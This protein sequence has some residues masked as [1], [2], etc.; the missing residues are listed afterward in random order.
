MKNL[1]T[2]LSFALISCIS[3]SQSSSSLPHNLTIHEKLSAL[4]SGY[5][6]PE[7]SE[8][9][10]TTPPPY[11]NLRAMAEWEEIQALVVSWTSYTGI[12]KQIVAASVGECHVIILSENP[13]ST[14]SYLQNS[15]YGGAVSMNNITIIDTN[16]NSI[17]VRDYGGTTVYGNEVDNGLLVDWIYNR[18]R[19]ADDITPAV[20]ASALGLDIYTTTSAPYDFM[21]TGGN[22][23]SDGFGTAFS[24]NLIL[25]ENSGGSTGWGGSFPNHTESEID[26]IMN[27][28]MGIDT[29]IKMPNLP[30]DGIH[31]ID[32]HMKLLDEETLLVSQYP[33]GTADGP[34]I[35]ANIQYVLQNYTTKW[36]TPFDVHWITA[37]PQQ[38]GGYPNSGGYY[39]TY[40]NSMFVNKTLLVP[41][42]YE[43]YDTTALRIYEE[44]LPGYTIVPIDCDNSPEAIISASGA[45]HCITHEIGVEDPLLISFQ[46]LENEV[47][48]PN[49]HTVSAYI[50]HRDGISLASI[51]WRVQGSFSFIPATMTS[52][53]GGYFE[54]AI[55]TLSGDGGVIEY[56][57]QA[58]SYSGKVQRRPMTAPSGFKSFTILPGSGIYGCTDVNACNYDSTA[59][60]DDGTCEP[61]CCP[62]DINGDGGMNVSDLLVI[63]SEF[64]CS[65]DCTADIDSDGSVT[66]G[67]ILYFLSIFSDGCP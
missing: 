34:Q 65:S 64:G 22:Y 1:L 60:I 35:E 48:N 44:L 66:V 55:P 6:R 32:M 43:Q 51:Y 52:I 41:T 59:T 29:Y 30:Y 24:S 47:S 50:K 18:P 17:W 40:T 46:A 45:I 5:E 14:Q 21:A 53:G 33:S 20:V 3:F 54:G 49:G 2:A 15:S 31:H 37:P 23:M 11:A 42:Y 9:A 12:L 27:D 8:R 13:S 19:P 26:A 4:Q 39:C 63:L 58:A 67:D 28:F 61:P 38:G 36:G 7:A 62:G 25:E 10:T 57:V 16:I 56:Y